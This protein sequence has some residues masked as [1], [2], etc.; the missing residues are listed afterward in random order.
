[1]SENEN[2]EQIMDGQDQELD[3]QDTEAAAE[4][5]EVAD[6]TATEVINDLPGGALYEV[7]GGTVISPEP[8]QKFQPAVLEGGLASSGTPAKSSVFAPASQTMDTGGSMNLLMDV[9]LELSVEL[10]RKCILVRDV[11]QLGAGSILELEKLSGE[12]VDVLVNGKL[13]ARGE[14]VVVDENFGVRVTEIV[15]TPDALHGGGIAV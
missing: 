6:E 3:I 8:E 1:M 11:L 15:S 14:V 9:Q 13:I 2:E 12:P 4:I 7:S 5:S 10:G